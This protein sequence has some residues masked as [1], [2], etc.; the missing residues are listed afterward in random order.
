MELKFVA[1]FAGGE[2]HVQVAL[3]GV[4][5]AAG[6]FGGVHGGAGRPEGAQCEHEH[7]HDGGHDNDRNGKISPEDIFTISKIEVIKSK[8]LKIFLLFPRKFP[9]HFLI[10]VFLP[11]F[12]F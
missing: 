4:E 1:V 5:R 2:T 10:L 11:S 8:C 9:V 6:E 3:D 12:H 7:A